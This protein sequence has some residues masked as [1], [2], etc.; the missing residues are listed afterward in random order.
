M[1][2]SFCRP[3]PCHHRGVAGLSSLVP[4]GVLPG[5]TPKSLA[6]PQALLAVKSVPVEEDPETEVPT[7]PEDGAPQ[8]G[9]SKVRG[10]ARGVRAGAGQQAGLGMWGSYLPR[11][12]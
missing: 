3:H 2:D 5:R 9:N 12:W 4:C 11:P 1:Q 6:F 7:H 8:P 10:S